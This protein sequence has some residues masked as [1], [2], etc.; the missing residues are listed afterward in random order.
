ML[1]LTA[2]HYAE[3]ILILNTLTLSANRAGGETPAATSL[4]THG[5]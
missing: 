5:L 3:A 4:A 1:S 2:V